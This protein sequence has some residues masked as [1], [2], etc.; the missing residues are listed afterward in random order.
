MGIQVA[1][2]DISKTTA[3]GY[4][5]VSGMKELIA[6]LR[7]RGIKVY[8]VANSVDRLSK[9]INTIKQDIDLSLIEVLHQKKV[10]GFK[11]S[12]NYINYICLNEGVQRNQI[13]Y[14][15]DDQKDLQETANTSVL[16]FL[17]K[18]AKP[19][20]DY[21]FPLEKPSELIDIIDRF[22]TKSNLWYYKIDDQDKSGNEVHIRALMKPDQA[23]SSGIM[24]LLKQKIDSGLIGSYKPSEYLFLHLLASIYLEGLHLAS[25]HMA[26]CLYPG[27]DQQQSGFLATFAYYAARFFREG[28]NPDLI[29]RHIPAPSSHKTRLEN[30]SKGVYGGLTIDKQLQTICLHPKYLEKGIIGHTVIVI[31]DFTTSCNSFEAARN[32]LY[33]AGAARVICIAA[34][35]YPTPYRAWSPL[36]T[37]TWDSFSPSPTLKEIHFESTLLEE[38]NTF[39][40]MVMDFFNDQFKALHEQEP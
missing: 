26:W 9:E 24:R 4:K 7:Q 19:A 21:G 6:G 32:F 39:D 8:F 11:G 27:H 31:D 5:L 13:I 25:N 17:A 33:N 38:R 14:L 18:W 34:G 15:G 2:I 22:F 40:E 23:Q 30:R 3:Q 36:P 37:T 29:Y 16:F 1:L 35:K 12:R 28:Y 10:G 20:I